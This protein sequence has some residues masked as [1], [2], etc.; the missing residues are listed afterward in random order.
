M[1]GKIYCMCHK[2]FDK[3][4]DP[5]YEA[6]HVGRA[7]SSDLGYPGDNIGENIS[8]LNPY[9]GELTGI[10]W[11]W[12][13]HQGSGNVGI[14]HYR[15]YL[16]NTSKDFFTD[17]EITSIL[18]DYDIIAPIPHNSPNTNRANYAEAHN[19]ADFM[20]VRA[21]IEKLCPDYLDAF[22]AMANGHISYYANLLIM[23]YDQYSK[24][25]AW[26]FSIIFEAWEKIDVS[27]Y[28]LYEQRVMGF[29][30]E[31]LLWVWATKN[32]KKVFEAPVI[33]TDEKAETRELKLAVGQ[34]LKNGDLTGARELFQGIIQ[35]R[36][37]VTLPM[38]DILREIPIIDHI[39]YIADLERAE[40]ISGL[41]NSTNDLNELILRYKKIC[42]IFLRIVNSG[43]SEADKNY[44]KEIKLSPISTAVV[45]M[46]DIFKGYEHDPLGRDKIIAALSPFFSKEDIAWLHETVKD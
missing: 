42:E 14:C 44:L 36:P 4:T 41:L 26:L 2:K 12:K 23:P 37:D 38:S 3:P 7:V 24:Y 18:K 21:A 33:C 31:V 11:V 43:F 8:D 10:Y 30:S 9:F 6:L 32:Q 19:D 16:A 13:N 40:G 39:L 29:L 1:S 17:D 15:R 22:D 27:T 5:M 20:A 25:C 34:L 45:L 35:L 28:N 46:G